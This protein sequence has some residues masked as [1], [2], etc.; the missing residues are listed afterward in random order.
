MILGISAFYHD[1]AVGLI[2]DDGAVLGAYHEERFSRKKA[3][4]GFPANALKKLIIDHGI[5]RSNLEAVV[6]FDKPLLKLARTVENMVAAWPGGFGQFCDHGMA[7]VSKRLREK[8]SVRKGLISAGLEDV[9]IYFSE[10]HISH[11]ASS[12]YCSGLDESLVITMDGVGEYA[13]GSVAIGAGRDL[14]ILEEMVY[15]HSLGLLYS[16]FTLFCGFKV[17][18]GEYKLMGLAPYGRPIY[19][20][21]IM[22]RFGDFKEDGSIKLNVGAFGFFN[23][24]SMVN[25]KFAQLM[26]AKPRPID[27]EQPISKFYCDVASSVQAVIETQVL[28]L[29]S[30]AIR[31][32][33][34]NN[35]CLAGGVALNCV[36]N[37]KL[38][39]IDGLNKLF[40][41]PAA[42]DAGGALGAALAFKYSR[43][44]DT[45]RRYM[46]PH[47]EYST[48]LGSEWSDSEIE[49]FLENSG[50]Q[51]TRYGIPSLCK[52][53]AS[54]LSEG[55]VVGW[56]QG[57]S[58]FGP[59]A[60]GNRSILADPR[61]KK[62][63]S[64]LNLKVKYRES[65]RPFAP[66]VL[67]EVADEY[68][69]MKGVNSPYMLNV[70]DVK[71]ASVARDEARRVCEVYGVCDKILGLIDSPIP[72]VTH[73]DLTARVQTVSQ[74][75]NPLFHR[76]LT[77][78]GEITGVPV[79]ANTSFN[80]R[81]EPIVD[82]PSDALRAFFCSGIDVLVLGPFVVNKSDQLCG[83][84]FCYVGKSE[85]D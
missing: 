3:D 49:T 16:A 40:I 70:F 50:V 28:R 14:R 21:L 85:L 31:R 65:F 46:M 75:N 36:A 76:L 25:K 2:G 18:S 48:Y 74:R 83:P 9:P 80:I 54:A 19:K 7:S 56:F 30:S 23:T 10:H 29:V 6:F 35:V 59:R 39:E 55:A 44:P 66:A 57:R 27:D 42:G 78:F 60:L 12:F 67:A 24:S 77:A 61:D 58:E 38:L 8:E 15:P 20:D 26:G 68:F 37:S 84:G 79:L 4:S 32:Y 72:A 63:Q 17:N 45:E 43:S 47:S 82:S 62:M 34:I 51:F 11:A 1:S 5:N 81:G 69:C 13:C 64:Y 52:H 53:V 41:Q 71:G 73:L 33:R 22:S